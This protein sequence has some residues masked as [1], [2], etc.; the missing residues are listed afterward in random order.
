MRQAGPGATLSAMNGVL[1]RAE[2]GLRVHALA[3]RRDLALP[4]VIGAAEVTG[5]LLTG[6]HYRY[7]DGRSVGGGA[8]RLGLILPAGHLTAL[9]W[10]LLAIGPVALVA[11]YRHPIAVVWLASAVA[12]APVL[13]CFGYLSLAVAC[14]TAVR[15]GHQRAAWTVIAAVYLA[16]LWLV[17]LAWGH[18]FVRPGAALAVGAWLAALVATAEVVLLRRER[19][20]QAKSGM[21]LDA[22]HRSDEERVR[23]AREL[24]DVI[25]HNISLI[26]IQAGV[27]LDLMDADPEQARAALAA[28][29]AV[30]GQALGELR[31]MLSALR[32]RGE[33]APR[34]PAPGLERLPELISLTSVA[35]LT[36]TTNVSGRRRALSAAVDLAAYRIVQESLTNVARHA[37]P[38]SATILLTYG[39][40]D[41]H[42]EVTDDGYAASSHAAGA[43]TGIPGMR[44]RAFALGGQLE[45]G[46]LPGRG[47]RV[48]ARLPFGDTA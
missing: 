32:D 37:G 16:A 43:G 46:R 15:S 14:F 10:I 38:A 33:E 30:S 8:V 42:I 36:V 41:L 24:H 28:V 4:V 48:R 9:A 17:P 7:Q 20:A 40:D 34:A 47:F 44:E 27:G 22:R 26:N 39:E 12:L 35:G 25:G 29:R 23:M 45:A 13:L 21:E 6:G 5:T 1:H 18:P 2:G 31:A 3:W 11:R 19:R